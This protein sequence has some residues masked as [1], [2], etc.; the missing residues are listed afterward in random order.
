MVSVKLALI[1]LR[2]A[3]E[4]AKNLKRAREL[5]LQASSQGAQIALLPE[6]FNMTYNIDDFEQFAEPIDTANPSETIQ[7]LSSMAKE[8]RLYL[9]G[10]SILER[11]TAADGTTSIF[12]TVTVWDPTGKLIAQQSKLHLFAID[13]NGQY[14]NEGDVLTAGAGSVGEF[15]TPWG[16]F[17]FGVCFDCR[18]PELAMIAARNGCIGM[19][20]PAAF[21]KNKGEV[22]WDLIMRTRAVDN[23]IFVAGCNPAFDEKS[24]YLACGNSMVVDPFAK[25]VAAAGYEE[26]VVVADMDLGLI[27]AARSS[28]PVYSQRRFDLYPDVAHQPTKPPATGLGFTTQFGS[29]GGDYSYGGGNTG[30][31][32]FSF[33]NTDGGNKGAGWMNSGTGDDDHK[34]RGGYQNQ[35]LRPVTIKQLLDIPVVNTDMPIVLDGEE[36]KQVTFV[37]VIRTI[38]PQAINITYGLE[39]GTGLIDLRVWNSDSAQD[40]NDANMD[41]DD[42]MQTMHADPKLVIGQ[43]ARVYGELKFFNGKR[44][45]NVHRIRPVTDHNEITYH[46]MSATYVHL[47]KVN[48]PPPAQGGAGQAK[49]AGHG[50]VTDFVQNSMYSAQGAGGMGGDV[51]G[52]GPVHMAVIASIKT[53]SQSPDGVQIQTIQQVLSGKFQRQQVF[54][55]IDEL[56]AD[57][58]LYNTID[59][60]YVQATDSSM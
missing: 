35:S 20:Y 12:N 3:N 60:T 42:G 50:G 43:Y 23:L 37:G 30:G 55:A 40:D 51:V 29:A 18:F 15:S 8:A 38:T 39:D 4:K 27:D 33:S 36:V 13:Y 19:L 31:Q 44:H 24:R 5:V 28:I 58:H 2:T 17:G 48:G 41:G 32:G 54:A 34:T 49:S 9:V 47:T 21:T 57:G 53:H 26:G 59:E 52:L 56:V 6:T 45:V 46:G 16:R 10:G 1:Q 25:V 7:A 14:E 22:H 11:R